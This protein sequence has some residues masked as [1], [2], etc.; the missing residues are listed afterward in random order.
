MTY[1]NDFTLP[2]ELLEQITA[3]G[4]EFLPELIRIAGQRRHESGATELS[5]SC[6]L[7][8][9]TRTPGP[10][11]WVQAEDADHPAGRDHL[12]RSPS[13]RRRFLS[14]SPGKRA[15]QRAGLAP[16]PGGDVRARRLHPQSDRP[17]SSSCVAPASRPPWSARQPPSWMRP[18]KP[19]ATVPWAK[20]SI[21]FWMPATRRCART[22]RSG[23]RPS[24]WPW[25]GS[26]GQPADPG[27]LGLAERSR[28]STGAPFCKAWSA[29][30]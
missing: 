24:C 9:F 13:A 30:A 12:R 17:S 6:T 28:K 26:T 3:Q 15:A 2:N 8:T 25:G 14:A 11:E 5:G 29:G 20:S 21:C 1:Q 16:G 27:G 23:M 22:G 10:C 19:G 18:W 7:P 4:F